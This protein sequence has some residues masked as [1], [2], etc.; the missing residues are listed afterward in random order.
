MGGIIRGRT[1]LET[2]KRFR[3]KVSRSKIE[4]ATGL[5]MDAG[6]GTKQQLYHS[7]RKDEETGEWVLYYHFGK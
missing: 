4:A 2:Y 3:A 5:Y 6:I 7:M 1:K